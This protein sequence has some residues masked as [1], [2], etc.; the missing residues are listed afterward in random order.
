[1]RARRSAGDR[2]APEPAPKTTLARFLKRGV[3]I[4]SRCESGLRGTVK[5][6]VARKTARRLGLRKHTTL[7]SNRVRCGVNAR[8]TAGSWS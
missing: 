1:M 8:R 4:R 7:V 3:R 6:Q 5:L 2:R